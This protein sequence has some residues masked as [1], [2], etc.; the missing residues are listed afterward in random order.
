MDRPAIVPIGRGGGLKGIPQS[1]AWDMFVS[2]FVAFATKSCSFSAG[3]IEKVVEA[4]AT[5]ECVERVELLVPI[6]SMSEL[7]AAVQKGMTLDTLKHCRSMSNKYRPNAL[8]ILWSVSQV[9]T[10]TEEQ[11]VDDVLSELTDETDDAICTEGD[12]LLS[13]LQHWHSLTDKIPTDEKKNTVY[14]STEKQ[15]LERLVSG[16]EEATGQLVILEGAMKAAK[17]TLTN[18]ERYQC[19]FAWAKTMGQNRYQKTLPI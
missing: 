10:G 14:R 7:T 5:R 18:E 9:V 1:D 16:V 17:K 12:E 19:V 6:E 15:S 11:S 13:R 8:Y 3:A 4:G 2:S